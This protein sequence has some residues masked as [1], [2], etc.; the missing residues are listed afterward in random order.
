MTCKMSKPCNKMIAQ[1]LL[2]DLRCMFPIYNFAAVLIR[3]EPKMY[4]IVTNML[5]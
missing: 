2:A 4:V 1:T 3:V 5:N